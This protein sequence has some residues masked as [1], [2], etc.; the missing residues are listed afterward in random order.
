M[1]V[2]STP[3]PPGGSV[4][5][6][7]ARKM[8]SPSVVTEPT[9]GLPYEGR[10]TRS[11]HEEA[12]NASTVPRG[13]RACTT[14][15]C[16]RFT[17]SMTA[18]AWRSVPSTASSPG[19]LRWK[20]IWASPAALTRSTGRSPVSGPRRCP[21]RR[22]T[23]TTPAKGARRPRR[24]RSIP[25]R[26]AG[27]SFTGLALTMPTPARQSA[28]AATAT[29]RRRVNEPAL[30]RSIACGLSVERVL[31]A[32]GPKLAQLLLLH[33]GELVLDTDQHSQVFPLDL[34]LDCHDPLGLA[35]RG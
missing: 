18:P 16:L 20:Y 28:A 29:A 3:K 8:P 11:T 15:P 14:V 25:W 5:T 22:P 7:S 23:P 9:R 35:E 33:L 2:P 10:V 32:V 27:A 6:S 13:T 17:R 24:A 4:R 19:Q 30:P 21:P 31:P 1:P 26:R 34:L 12:A